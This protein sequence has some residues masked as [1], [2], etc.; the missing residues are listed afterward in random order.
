MSVHHSI[1]KVNT[2]KADQMK[3]IV[4]KLMVQLKKTIIEG[5]LLDGAE[6][7]FIFEKTDGLIINTNP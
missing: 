4:D 3:M 1:A 7:G 6:M 5:Q 2:E